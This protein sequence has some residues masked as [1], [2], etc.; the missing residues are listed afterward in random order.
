MATAWSDSLPAEAL[1]ARLVNVADVSVSSGSSAM[2]PF[3]GEAIDESSRTFQCLATAVYYE[4]RGEGADGMAAVA[5]VILNRARHPAFPHSVCGVVYQPRQF[6][7]VGGGLRAPYGPLWAEARDI[8]ERALGGYVMSRVGTST[9]FHAQRVSPS[10]P[11]M[12]RVATIGQHIFYAYAGSRGAAQAFRASPDLDDA[13]SPAPR[14]EYAR[15]QRDAA[16]ALS[17]TAAPSPDV[18]VPEAAEAPLTV[19]AP[20]V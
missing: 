11:G 18:S 4:A 8:A 3:A 10:W 1:G 7:F 19:P 5:Q 17:A 16:P 15:V 2:S 20:V 13:G 14:R 6:S 12:R 9:H